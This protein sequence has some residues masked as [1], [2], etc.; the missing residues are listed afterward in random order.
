MTEERVVGLVTGCASVFGSL[1][2]LCHYPSQERRLRY[3]LYIVVT[4]LVLCEAVVQ[5]KFMFSNLQQLLDAPVSSDEMCRTMAAL[6]QFFSVASQFWY[7]WVLVYVF[8]AIRSYNV[9]PLW[10]QHASSWGYAGLAAM[11]PLIFNSYGRGSGWYGSECWVLDEWAWL[12]YGVFWVSFIFLIYLGRQLQRSKMFAT[13]LNERHVWRLVLY[14]VAYLLVQL[15]SSVLIFVPWESPEL[16]WVKFVAY[17]SKGFVSSM[18]W[19]LGPAILHMCGGP[20]RGEPL[21]FEPNSSRLCCWCFKR[22]QKMEAIDC[23]TY[24]GSRVLGG[25][26]G[27]VGVLADCPTGANSIKQQFSEDPSFDHRKLP[28]FPG[29]S[30]LDDSMMGGD[31]RVSFES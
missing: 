19:F 24:A 6:D 23:G 21:L 17:G 11:L 31:A 18:V 25:E 28:L 3:R 1:A 12:Y 10:V 7:M 26:Y 22:S 15:L 8:V 16:E 5:A 29:V 14:L 20:R 2:M 30:I 27:A 4:L 13:S 9:P